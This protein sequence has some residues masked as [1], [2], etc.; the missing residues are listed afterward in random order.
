M[1]TRRLAARARDDGITPAEL[2]G[3]TFTGSNLGLY[4]MT[5]ITPVINVPQAVIL[6]VGAS[7]AV[8]ALAHGRLA[9][10]QL[11]TLRLSCDHRILY[12]AGSA[13]FLSA[14]RAGLE[15]PAGLLM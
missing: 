7:R 5:A 10:R 11:M 4:R 12:G 14:I 6:G 1:E 13:E 9:E 8:P 15:Q 3:A 2:S